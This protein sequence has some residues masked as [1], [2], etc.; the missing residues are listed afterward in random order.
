[1]L[2]ESKVGLE[3]QIYQAPNNFLPHDGKNG[4]D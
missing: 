2:Y 1:M 4:L 3:N